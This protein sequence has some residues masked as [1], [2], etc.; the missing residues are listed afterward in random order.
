MIKAGLMCA[1]LVMV[2]GLS[3]RSQYFYKDI[4]SNQ[5]AMKERIALKE[6]KIRKIKVHSF[7]GNGEVSPGFFCEKEIGKDYRKMETYTRSNISGKSLM[8]SYYN[9]KDQ[10]VR[11]SDSSD[12]S[13]STSIYEY[14]GN[15]NIARITSRSHSNDDDFSTQLIEEHVYTYNEKGRP[16]K[17]LR[18]RNGKD[19][20]WIIFK[21]DEQGNVI[22]EIDNSKNGKHYYYY[23]NDKNRLTDIVKFNVVRNK[24][25]P[26]FV[27]EYNSDGQVTQMVAVEEGVSNDY[28]TW[29]YTYNDG[30]RIIEKC[31]SKEKILLGYFEY[32]YD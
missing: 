8:T 7:E 23:Y 1:G 12:L 26:D 30:L 27:F 20:A 9:D 16:V 11:A 6:Q 5:V 18:T 28:Y 19:S 10:L 15:G 4:L 21:H 24:L 14:D 3:A 17:M 31:F 32:E 25:V 13:V 29:K 22:D 2:A